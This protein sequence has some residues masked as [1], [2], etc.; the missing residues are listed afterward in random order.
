VGVTL[1]LQVGVNCAVHVF[2]FIFK[3]MHFV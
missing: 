2:F 3:C 1:R